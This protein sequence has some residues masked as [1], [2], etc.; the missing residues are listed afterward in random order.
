M[1][2]VTNQWKN[3]HKNITLGDKKLQTSEIKSQKYKFRPQ[4]VTN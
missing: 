2:N 3:G 1:K 4:K